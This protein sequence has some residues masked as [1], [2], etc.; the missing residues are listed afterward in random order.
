PARRG[1]RHVRALRRLACREGRARAAPGG[2]RREDRDPA[3]VRAHRSAVQHGA[4]RR[5]VR[6]AHDLRTPRR[7]G[8]V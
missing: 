1:A 2:D 8:A 6:A 5:D 4:H 3:R 7:S